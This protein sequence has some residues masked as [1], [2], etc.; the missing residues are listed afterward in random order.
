[1]IFIINYFS[2][3][4]SYGQSVDNFTPALGGSVKLL[5]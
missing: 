1:L 4:I 5:I 3:L 2:T